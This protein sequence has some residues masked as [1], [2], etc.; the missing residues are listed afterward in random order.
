[1]S[2][3]I[4]S[5]IMDGD[6]PSELLYEDELCVVIRDIN[7]QAPI[8]LLVIPRKPIATLAD[9]QREDQ[10]LLGHLMLVAKTMA[11]EQGIGDGFRLIINNGESVG[12]TVY[13]LHLHVMGGATFAEGGMAG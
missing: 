1:M 3:T 5:M 13:H 2:K 12:M 11:T 10:A 6:I 9:A 7:P 4:F 8:H